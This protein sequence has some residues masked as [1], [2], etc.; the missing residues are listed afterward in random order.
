MNWINNNLIEEEKKIVG[1]T[2]VL[3][4]RWREQ[5]R[6]WESENSSQTWVQKEQGTKEEGKGRHK[7]K[8]HPRETLAAAVY[9]K[10]THYLC[11]KENK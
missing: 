7:T 9:S 11:D 4:Y 1:Q 2:A 5:E 10:C 8:K 3:V 6:E